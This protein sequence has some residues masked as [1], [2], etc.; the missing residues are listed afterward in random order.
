MTTPVAY[1]FT[2]NAQD[3]D[4][5]TL[6]DAFEL[7]ECDASSLQALRTHQ[8]FQDATIELRVWR[9]AAKPLPGWQLLDT[10]QLLQRCLEED[11]D[12]LVLLATTGELWS[13]VAGCMSGC[14][15]SHYVGG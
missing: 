1:R 4:P 10:D 14:G 7:A 15:G 2:R 11:P 12:G 8:Q 3:R 5:P 9:K 13:D 6:Y